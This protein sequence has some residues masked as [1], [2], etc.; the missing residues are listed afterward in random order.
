M[1]VILED[2]GKT[3]SVNK[4]YMLSREQFYLDLLF[5]FYPLFNL[6]ISPSAGSTLGFKH[7]SDF[8]K[9]RSSNLNPMWNKQLSPEFIIMQKR[10]KKGINNPLYVGEAYKKIK[11][12]FS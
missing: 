9:K 1:L 8:R 2:L 6:N 11:Y 10:D 7:S 12:N 4:N 5:K 3:G